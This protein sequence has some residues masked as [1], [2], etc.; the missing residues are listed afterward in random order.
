MR[1]ATRSKP[2]SNS[3]IASGQPEYTIEYR[4]THRKRG[5][6]RLS[7][8]V[9]IER[10]PDGTAI[11]LRGTAQDVTELR[12]VE[13]DLRASQERLDLA[14]AGTGVSLWDWTVYSG[15]YKFD[16]RMLER[17]GYQ[18]DE[19][20]FTTSAWDALLHRDDL[21]AMGAALESYLKGQT[22]FFQ[23]IYRIR[24]K[25][26]DWRWILSRGRAVER[27]ADGLARRMSGTHLDITDLKQIELALRRSD[28][29]FR[30]L[31][32]SSRA[33]PWEADFATYRITYVGPAD[34]SGRRLPGGRMGR[35]GPVAGAAASGG[36]RP[37]AARGGRVFARRR[38]S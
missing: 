13:S 28:E 1:I 36:P 22:D 19:V 9:S 14:L 17:M 34:R 32:E 23:A 25:T 27:G 10:A 20:A 7:A 8:K 26:G 21:S 6:R 31:A 30:A 15:E 11:R 5:I 12:A 38:R 4:I 3:I 37:G 33:I 16:R 18:P 24:T 2:R 29:R 35:Q